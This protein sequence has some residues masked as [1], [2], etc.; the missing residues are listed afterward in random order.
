MAHLFR[1]RVAELR[2]LAF[3]TTGVAL[4]VFAFPQRWRPGKVYFPDIKNEDTD[5]NFEIRRNF[6]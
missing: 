5:Q 1:K 4:L 2:K 3:P 6:L